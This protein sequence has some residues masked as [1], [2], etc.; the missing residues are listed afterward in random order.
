MMGILHVTKSTGW[1]IQRSQCFS[2]TIQFQTF[3]L[4]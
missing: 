2:Q 4:I 1:L 3:K